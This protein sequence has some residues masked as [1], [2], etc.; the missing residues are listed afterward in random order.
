MFR[1]TEA[2][3]V[4][5]DL[6]VLA[7][8]A[9]LVV[10]QSDFAFRANFAHVVANA[11]FAAGALFARGPV[12]IRPVS[13]CTQRTGGAVEVGEPRKQTLGARKASLE[14]VRVHSSAT[15]FAG[16][17]V[18]QRLETRFACNATRLIRVGNMAMT[19]Q[20]ARGTRRPVSRA[21]RARRAGLTVRRRLALD[22]ARA[23]ETR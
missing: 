6:V 3:A 23:E 15:L 8:R 21:C 1:R 5:S 14:V 20:A 18:W 12:L 2:L 22:V 10:W 9:T 16:R 7:Q 19:H 11:K 4:D 13:R 17:V